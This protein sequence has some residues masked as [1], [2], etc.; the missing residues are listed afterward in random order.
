[1]AKELE[2][3][4]KEFPRLSPSS[5]RPPVGEEERKHDSIFSTWSSFSLILISL[6]SIFFLCNFVSLCHW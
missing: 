6:L 4:E 1:L 5:T 2:K 3:N